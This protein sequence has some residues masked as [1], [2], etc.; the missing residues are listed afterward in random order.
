[1]CITPAAGY[2]GPMSALIMGL[3]VSPVCYWFV[4]VAKAKLGYDD[5]LDAFGIHGIGG[6]VGAVL[7]GV[8]CNR[9]YNAAGA[10]GLVMGE[11]NQLASQL[12]AVAVTWAFAFSVTAIVVKLLDVT[13]GIRARPEDEDAGLDL[14]Q[15]GEVGY[16]L[17][18]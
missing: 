1:V 7:T 13:V 10:N 4:T 9:D 16:N 17:A 14:S 3:A 2:V 5:S 6:T 8:F 15:H 12:I 11:W 18:G